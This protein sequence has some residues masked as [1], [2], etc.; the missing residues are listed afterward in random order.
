MKKES[1][2]KKQRE[3][4]HRQKNLPPKNDITDDDRLR[5]LEAMKRIECEQ[6]II[7]Q[8]NR[9]IRCE[10]DIPDGSAAMT[11]V[12][13]GEQEYP[14]L[15]IYA[16]HNGFM[17]LNEKGQIKKVPITERQYPLPLDPILQRLRPMGLSI[18]VIGHGFNGLET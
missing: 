8:M 11:E 15:E 2:N 1:D 9:P 3:S 17:T 10:L 18:R 12:A 6:S 4:D 7:D 13:A 14:L 16:G 5:W